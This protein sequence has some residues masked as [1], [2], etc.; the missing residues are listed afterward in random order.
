M[1]MDVCFSQP[2]E[3]ARLE[4]QNELSVQ[5]DAR[6]RE[7]YQTWSPKV[8]EIRPLISTLVCAK[9]AAP[10][11]RARIPGGVEEELY[12]VISWDLVG[13]CMAHEYQDF[14]GVSK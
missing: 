10:E 11:V 6:R 12:S 5:L 7:A 2:S 9:L 13:L 3:D 14:V 4:A 1:T 8:K